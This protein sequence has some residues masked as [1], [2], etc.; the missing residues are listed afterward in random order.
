MADERRQGRRCGFRK[1]E[2]S[3]GTGSDS[4]SEYGA[5][6]SVFALLSCRDLGSAEIRE[7]AIVERKLQVECDC[8]CDRWD[9]KDLL[10]DNNCCT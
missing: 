2:I 9:D 1:A 10:E 3:L 6:R 4:V 7:F 8:H 5:G